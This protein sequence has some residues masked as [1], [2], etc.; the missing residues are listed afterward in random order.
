[1]IRSMT[2]FGTAAAEAD[3]CRFSIEV[4][5]VNN[6]FFKA[7]V[8][9]PDELSTLE[10]ACES[11]ISKRRARGRVTVVVRFIPGGSVAV[12]EVNP[13]AAR[14]ALSFVECVDSARGVTYYANSVTGETVWALPPGGVVTQRMQR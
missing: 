13:A 12:V 14:S 8:R 7:T 11:A 10:T 5:S 6:R 9:L 4:K 1:M 2:G 3:G